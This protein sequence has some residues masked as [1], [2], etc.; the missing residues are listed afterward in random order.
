MRK[1]SDF[2]TIVE[3]LNR[4]TFIC[5]SGCHEFQGPCNSHGY[6]HLSYDGYIYRAHIT[7][8]ELSNGP[9]PTGKCVL[10]K[11][12]NRRCVNVDHLFLGTYEDNAKDMRNKGRDTYGDNFGENNGQAV[13]TTEEVLEIRQMLASNF[14]TSTEIGAMFGVTRAAVNSIKSRRTWRHLQ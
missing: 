4:L 9:I 6:G 1:S 12:D 7:S 10:H 5:D 8:W 11:C 3:K 14:H 2:E 13:L